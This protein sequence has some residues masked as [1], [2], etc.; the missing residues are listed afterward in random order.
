[1]SLDVN[2]AFHHLTAHNLCLIRFCGVSQRRFSPSV[3]FVRASTR[4]DGRGSGLLS[5]SANH[6]R[7]R[8][9]NP[10][11]YRSE[12]HHRPV[13]IDDVSAHADIGTRSTE[14]PNPAANEQAVTQQ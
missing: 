5:V 2:S 3:A 6:T 8:Q 11:Q 1:M 13:N 10:A 9:S 12:R 14:Q 7:E 4:L